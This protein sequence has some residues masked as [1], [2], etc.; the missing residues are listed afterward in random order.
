M[1]TNNTAA[2]NSILDL[3]AEMANARRAYAAE[4]GFI[5]TDEEIADSIKASLIKMM[6]A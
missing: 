6:S 2:A 5:A 3:I 1:T 4:N